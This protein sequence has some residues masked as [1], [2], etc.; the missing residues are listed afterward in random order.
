MQ[1]R[2]AQNL[3]K[4]LIERIGTNSKKDQVILHQLLS[5]VYP[6]LTL[7]SLV[8]KAMIQW[9]WLKILSIQ[10]TY[11]SNCGRARSTRTHPK[12]KLMTA[13]MSYMIHRISQGLLCESSLTKAHGETSK[14][15]T[16]QLPI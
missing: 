7:N 15:I 1:P 10:Q 2:K 3:G 16:L 12:G 11:S 6:E 14:R 9:T 8:T 13:E 4:Q 5:Q